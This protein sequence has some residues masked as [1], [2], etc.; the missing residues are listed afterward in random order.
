MNDKIHAATPANATPHES[1]SELNDG[2]ASPLAKHAHTSHAKVVLAAC[3]LQDLLRSVSRDAAESVLLMHLSTFIITDTSTGPKPK[4]A[5]Q[6]VTA[7]LPSTSETVGERLKRIYPEHYVHIITEANRTNG[8]EHTARMLGY[9]SDMYNIALSA[10][11][12]WERSTEGWDFWARL[13]ERER[14]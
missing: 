11:F 5:P 12:S 13:A 9:P 10:M 3:K 7:P 14:S 2:F 4:G 1:V 8:A 6:G